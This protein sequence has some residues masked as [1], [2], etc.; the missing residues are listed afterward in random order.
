MKDNRVMVLDDQARAD[1]YKWNPIDNSLTGKPVD[2]NFLK[3]TIYYYEVADNLYHH[4][5][6]KTKK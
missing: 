1:F 6:L 5:G 3:T 4:G 2:K